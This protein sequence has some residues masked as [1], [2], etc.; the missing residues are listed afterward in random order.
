MLK[1]P[2]FKMKD[3][4]Q[5]M[6]TPMF[7]P[8]FNKNPLNEFVLCVFSKVDQK[9]IKQFEIFCLWNGLLTSSY[10]KFL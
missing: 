6:V 9:K 3:P 2:N 10:L 8:L 5:G 4:L 7:I 1:L